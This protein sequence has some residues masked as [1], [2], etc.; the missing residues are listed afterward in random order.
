[1]LVNVPFEAREM[2]FQVIT[3]RSLPDQSISGEERRVYSSLVLGL[4][5]MFVRID[6]HGLSEVRSVPGF[7]QELL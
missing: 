6:Q 4:R 3:T 5:P 7:M 2:Y 1:M